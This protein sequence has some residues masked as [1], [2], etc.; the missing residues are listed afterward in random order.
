MAHS[1]GLFT[2]EFPFL[3]N[4][5]AQSLEGFLFPDTYRFSPETEARAIVEKM[6]LTFQNKVFQE[7]ESKFRESPQSILDIIIMASMIERESAKPEDRRMTSD[8]LWRRLEI[9]MPLQVDATVIYAWQRINPRWSLEG[10]PRLSFADLKVDSPYNT[11]RV[12]GLPPGPIANPGLDS[13]RAALNPMNNEYWFY[14]SPSDGTTHYSRTFEE[15]TALK[16][17][18]FRDP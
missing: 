3:E 14:L 16:A 1:P 2:E 10:R 18:L 6:L 7:L 12:R 9:G 17:K 4:L 11:Y 8:I 5:N 13:I 15:H